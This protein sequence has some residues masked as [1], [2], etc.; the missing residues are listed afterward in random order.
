[1]RFAGQYA[2]AS[3]NW[4]SRLFKLN[5][6]YRFGSNE[7]KAARQRNSGAEEESKRVQSGDNN[8]IR[9]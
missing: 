3:G 1:M 7:V 9:Q 6:S 8:G 4:E 2:V 5:F